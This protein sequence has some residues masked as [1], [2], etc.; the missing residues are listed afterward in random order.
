MIALLLVLAAFDASAAAS[1]PDAGFR[2]P[3]D[4]QCDRGRMDGPKQQLTCVG[5]VRVKRNT[6]DIT[7]D[8]LIA[9]YANR[10][11][12]EVK[13]FECIGNVEAVDGDRWARSDYADFNNEKEIL[14]MTGN[15]E[16]RQGRNTMRGT[17]ITFYVTSD[18]IDVENVTGVLESKGQDEKRKDKKKKAATP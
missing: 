2:N 13:R 5:H 6:T 18:L 3:V 9:Y 15:P 14:V 4:I 17:K 8:R 1:G 16:A 7:C 10:D 12:N 11:V